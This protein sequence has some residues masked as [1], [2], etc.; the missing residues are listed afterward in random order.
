VLQAPKDDRKDYET[1]TFPG[2]QVTSYL[3][4]WGVADPAVLAAGRAA[5]ST[6]MVSAPY[7]GP[8][9]PVMTAT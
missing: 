8:R 1:V 4:A 9:Q 5:S 2:G 6:A 7:S 3:P